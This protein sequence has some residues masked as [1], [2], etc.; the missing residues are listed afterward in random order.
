MYDVIIILG[1]TATGKTRLSIELA[2]QI[3]A[4]IINADSM[5]M[6]KNFNIGTS[7]PD[8]KE[9]NGIKHYLIDFLNS[10]DE[11]SVSQFNTDSLKII[12]DLK[13]QNIVPIVVGGTGFYLDSLI[14]DYSFGNTIKNEEIRKK[15]FDLANSFGNEYIYNILKE[16]DIETANTLHS[17]DLKRVVRALEIFDTTGNSKSNSVI[18]KKT[19]SSSINPLLIGLNI[20]RELLY[21]KINSR[22]DYMI[23]NGLLEEA[24][25]LYTG[26]TNKN[27]QCMK[28]IGYKEL[29][30]YFDNKIDLPTAINLIKQHTRNY[31]K[32]QI[33]WF[34][35]YDNVM[36]FDSSKL[37]NDEIIKQILETFKSN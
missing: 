19:I 15:Y 10:N 36:W 11:Y 17:N 13:N 9:R 2:K 12:K 7:K 8:E 21:E 34:K 22:V 6:Y 31:A 28:A 14:Y 3:N 27:N 26:N 33:T 30:D 29:F 32:R 4:Q 37:N 35:R 24:K 18:N 23:N 5:Y 20:P 16:K 1:P 25:S